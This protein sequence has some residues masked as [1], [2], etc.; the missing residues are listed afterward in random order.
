MYAWLKPNNNAG[1]GK[2]QVHGFL[3]GCNLNT[4]NPS[5]SVRTVNGDS[6]ADSGFGVYVG[7]SAVLL[8]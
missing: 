7:A 6:P 3:V 5:P 4:W 2:R 1:N 8:A